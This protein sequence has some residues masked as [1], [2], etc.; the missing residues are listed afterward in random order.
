MGTT[1]NT[2]ERIDTGWDCESHL[3]R[4][5]EQAPRLVV[6]TWHHSNE[7]KPGIVH[8]SDPACY[9]MIRGWLEDCVAGRRR[10]IAHNG[11]FDWAVIC[12]RFP[13]L[14]PLVFD[15][16][17]ADSIT[18]T[19]IRQWLLDN[20]AGRFRGYTDDR[21]LYHPYMYD[22]AALAK[23]HCGVWLQKD[24]WRTSYGLFHGYPLE[25]WP[26]RAREVQALA[27]Q[28][29]VGLLDVL[30]K[31]E[32]VRPKKNQDKK[33]IKQLKDRLVALEDMIASSP[34]RATEYALEDATAAL[35]VH[36]KQE[37][38]ADVLADQFRQTRAYFALNLQS[39]WGIRTDAHGVQILK[40]G[41]RDEL[42]ELTEELIEEGLVRE[43]GV[44]DEK[45]AKE[46]M[47]AVCKANGLR[48]IRTDAHVKPK[49]GEPCPSECSCGKPRCRDMNRKKGHVDIYE[50]FDH[51]EFC[52][53]H[54][55]LDKDAC[56]AVSEFDP[57]FDTLAKY[58]TLKKNLTNDIVLLENASEYPAHTRYGF[59][60]TGRLTASKP[61]LTNQSKREG[62]REA[63][64]ARCSADY[65][66]PVA[67]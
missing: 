1:T 60:Q 17:E 67:A 19:M 11:S 8:H 48:V 66:G 16:F 44:A 23:R 24:A 63:F 20:A 31:H 4:P 39:I 41:I 47:I 50:D 49:N 3:I 64:I 2:T 18:D 65:A 51:P 57:L 27:V 26:T 35:A 54:V 37:A 52:R 53:D 21:G 7:A 22:L 61:N 6:V 12:V 55:G 58:K 29:R 33:A 43:N 10:C 5:A 28:E 36:D 9:R 13:D 45:K 15:A 25:K 46:R 14:M 40:A 32:A 30:G 56:E 42:E 59:A 38:H 34:E 62:I